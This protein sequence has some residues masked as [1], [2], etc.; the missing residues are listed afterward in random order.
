MVYMFTGSN[1][2][3]SQASPFLV[4]PCLISLITHHPMI[5][6]DRQRG[7]SMDVCHNHTVELYPDSENDYIPSGI[8]T[9]FYGLWV[10]FFLSH[11]C[12]HGRWKVLQGRPK[13]YIPDITVH[14][15]LPLG[16]GGE[17]LMKELMI[18]TK[19]GVREG[20]PE[21]SAFLTEEEPPP[22]TFAVNSDSSKRNC[23]DLHI[24]ATNHQIST[25][26]SYDTCLP[27]GEMRS[28]PFLGGFCTWQGGLK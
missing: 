9:N 20:T 6:Q 7:P 1:P 23:S 11:K 21:E 3:E 5:Q 18:H 16:W 22:C 14:R 19:K 4:W 17:R 24:M 28:S 12:Q 25:F 2:A 13:K 8:H 26:L 27:P 15:A 10:I